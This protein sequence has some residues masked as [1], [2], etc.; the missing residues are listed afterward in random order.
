[1]NMANGNSNISNL[2]KNHLKCNNIER[3]KIREGKK[4]YHTNI[5]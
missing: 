4:V 1:M 3:L 5:K 2:Q